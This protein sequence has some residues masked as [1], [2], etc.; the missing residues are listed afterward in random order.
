M[1]WDSFKHEPTR[2]VRSRAKLIKDL[3]LGLP[4]LRQMNRADFSWPEILERVQNFSG[5]FFNPMQVRS[6][7]LEALEEIEAIKPRV[8]LE[9][10]TANGGT[11]FLLSR[12]ASPDATLISVDLPGG[13]FG[14]GYSGWKTA[15]Y[16]SFLLPGQKGSFVRGDSHADDTVRAVKSILRGRELDLLFI[17]GD[18]TYQGVKQ[19]FLLYSPLVS[20]AGLTIFHD[21]AFH[22]PAKNTQVDVF[23]A[24]VS[25]T[26]L[27]RTIIEDP[28]QGWAGIGILKTGVPAAGIVD[29]GDLQA[30]ARRESSK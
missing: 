1:S 17:D 23:W 3:A 20:A 2:Y 25:K 10:G 22:P 14:G 11:L 5:G 16:R 30:R 29:P 13:H 4:R 12:A 15:I 24:E 27:S 6:E 28:H 9:I 19:D 18:H 26:C 21:I 7:I 8:I